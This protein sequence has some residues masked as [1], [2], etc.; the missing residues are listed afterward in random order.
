MSIVSVVHVSRSKIKGY[1]PLGV[2]KGRLV[3]LFITYSIFPYIALDHRENRSGE[4]IVLPL[5]K[6]IQEKK[7]G[8]FKITDQQG[9]KWDVDF[10]VVQGNWFL[11]F[12]NRTNVPI[13]RTYSCYPSYMRAG[14]K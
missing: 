13:P 11:P 8:C 4:T 9:K 6:S 12:L 2:S 3:L 10:C 14:I 5:F 7:T 1:L